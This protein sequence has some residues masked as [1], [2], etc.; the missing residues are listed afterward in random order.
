MILQ[1]GDT[2]GPY[3]IDSPVGQGGMAVVYKAHHARLD[4]YVAIKIMHESFLQDDDFRERFARE[5]RIVA[6]LEHPNIVPIYDYNE[7]NNVPY[8]VMKYIDGLTLKRLAFKRGLSLVETADMMAEIAAAMDYA[9]QRNIL[10]RDMKPSNIIIDSDNR[11]YITDFGLARIAEVGASTISHDVMLGTPYYISPEQARGEKE[12]DHHTDLYS[13]G[14][15]LYE[16]IA[17]TVPFVADTPYAIVHNHI[18][19]P[20]PLPSEHNQDLSPEIDAVLIRALAKEPADRYHSATEMIQAFKMALDVSD[21]KDP[22]ASVVVT[23]PSVKPKNEDAPA[24]PRIGASLEVRRDEKGRRLQVESS[25][26]MGSID[27]NDLGKRF[28]SSVQNLTSMIEDRI[29]SELQS[30]GGKITMSEEEELR[31]R[32]AKRLKKRQE[33]ASHVAWYLVVNM[34]LWAIWFF[35]G[36]G[37]PWPIFPTFFWGL[38]VFGDITDYYTK[39][40]PGAQ[41]RE[42]YIDRE[43]ARELERSNSRRGQF[44]SKN[45]AMPLDEIVGGAVRLNE[46]GE[47]TE[48]FVEEQQQRARRR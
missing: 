38:G 20:V 3:T 36:G 24:Q 4:R 26:D 19:Q 39:Y 40:G 14:I 41:K 9:H 44:K 47:F 23:T 16:L 34:S 15:I 10:H 11:P 27:F 35:V 6:R 43:V 1:A 22:S 32:I 13:L 5:A 30:R 8:L 48:S 12:L 29:D 2:V 25:F 46:D 17:G 37:F 18:Y 21:V 31:A 42:E 45:D 7:Y 28:S 33:V